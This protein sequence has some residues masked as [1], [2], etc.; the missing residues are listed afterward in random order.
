MRA[1]W[2]A[3]ALAA[4][5]YACG[6]GGKDARAPSALGPAPAPNELRPVTAFAVI[7]DRDA[8]SRALFR[9]ASRVF[10]HPR[11]VNCHPDGDVPHQGMALALHDPPVE[12][13]PT[14]EGVVGMRCSTCHQ[15]RNQELARV[16]G[17]PSWHLAPRSMAWVGRSPRQL[18]EQIK[19]PARN[20]RKTLAQIVEHSTHDKLVGWGWTPGHDRAPAPGTQAQFGALVAAWVETGAVCPEEDAR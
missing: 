5:L 19:D 17:A 8:R 1:G 16:P 15:D 3:I 6:G 13:G 4:A 14:D 9:E 2:R 10:M 11:C 12:R 7:T 18:C 20:G